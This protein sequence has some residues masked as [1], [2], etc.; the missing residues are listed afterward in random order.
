MKRI[1]FFKTLSDDTYVLLCCSNCS[2]TKHRNCMTINPLKCVTIATCSFFWLTSPALSP[3]TTT[4]CLRVFT[5]NTFF[6]AKVI[7]YVS[8]PH[9]HVHFEVKFNVF[10]SIICLVWE[11]Y[12]YKY[13]CSC[14]SWKR[15][16]KK[17]LTNL[18]TKLY[19]LKW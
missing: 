12:K 16:I 8:N 19:K 18:E 15:M 1:M 4:R 3:M 9:V 2:N 10:I 13:S 11:K 17:Y 6:H 5:L 7:F 14:I